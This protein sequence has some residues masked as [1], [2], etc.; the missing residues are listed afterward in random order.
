MWSNS[1]FTNYIVILKKSERI[2]R[3]LVFDNEN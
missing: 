3:P 2:R 1:T